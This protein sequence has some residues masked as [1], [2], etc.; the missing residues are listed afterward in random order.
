MTKRHA[1]KIKHGDQVIYARRRYIVTGTAGAEHGPKPPYLI[2]APLAP[3]GGS[4]EVTYLLC[5][6]AR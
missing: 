6:P 1:E 3:G 2:L 5:Q 4:V